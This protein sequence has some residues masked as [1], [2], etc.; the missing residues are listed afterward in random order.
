MNVEEHETF[1][2]RD[3]I[4]R[5]FCR[6]GER[7]CTFTCAVNQMVINRMLNYSSVKYS[8]QETPETSASNS[9]VFVYYKRNFS[10]RQ[11]KL[12]FFICIMQRKLFAVRMTFYFILFHFTGCSKSIRLSSRVL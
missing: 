12:I 2:T 5:L 9:I 8:L 6:N 10:K 3:A 4:N 11:R 1:L 7:R